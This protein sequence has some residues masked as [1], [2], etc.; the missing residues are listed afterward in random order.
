MNAVKRILTWCFK[1]THDGHGRVELRET[2]VRATEQYLTC[3]LLKDPQWRRRLLR[4]RDDDTRF[5]NDNPYRRLWQDS[6][7]TRSPADPRD[8][9]DKEHRPTT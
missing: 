9:R 3:G 1:R 6:A 7:N 8:L 2:M 5:R 4:E